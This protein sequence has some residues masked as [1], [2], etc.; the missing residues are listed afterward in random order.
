MKPSVRTTLHGAPDPVTLARGSVEGVVDEH[1][2]RAQIGQLIWMS[3]ILRQVTGTE[4][5][6]RA[7]LFDDTLDHLRDTMLRKAQTPPENGGLDL[8]EVVRLGEIDGWI[9]QLAIRVVKTSVRTARRARTRAGVDLPIPV[10]P[11]GDTPGPEPAGPNGTRPGRPSWQ[12]ERL[13]VSKPGAA[14]QSCARWRTHEL[15]LPPLEHRA[16]PSADRLAAA[17]AADP[18]LVSRVIARLLG[19]RRA[20]VP[21]TVVERDLSA[22]L[23]AS[24]R[25]SDCELLLSEPPLIAA[26]LVL[27]SV[28]PRPRIAHLV[29]RTAQQL[30]S[31][32]VPGD[33]RWARLAGDLTSAYVEVLADVPSE[34]SPV[35]TGPRDAD[36]ERAAQERLSRHVDRAMRFPGAPL[37]RTPETVTAALAR[38]IVDAER[39]SGTRAALAA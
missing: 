29:T 11:A 10:G 23:M 20:D 17:V 26:V 12:D 33:T 2:A 15:G 24:Y 18:M 19:D 27:A 28:T 35:Q 4:V 14:L 8:Q 31:S 6:S 1:A 3:P 30:L 34:S 21:A 9:R 38:L 25:R 37:G 5:G 39:V 32:H 7:H 36:A 22:H 13:A 16:G